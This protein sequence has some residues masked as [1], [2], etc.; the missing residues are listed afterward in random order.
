MRRIYKIVI[1]ALVPI[2]TIPSSIYGTVQLGSYLNEIE[3]ISNLPLVEITGYIEYSK[4]F[5][6]FGFNYFI[7]LDEK[8]TQD[9]GEE[10]IFLDKDKLEQKL[11]G[12]KV[13]VKGHFEDEYLE[14]IFFEGS[15]AG[16]A[17]RNPVIFVKEIKILN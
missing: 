16:D 5:D 9:L 8:Y 10:K 3:Y 6:R 11:V 7:I 12:N 15:D 14:I 17:F 13:M 2:I 4:E 1:W